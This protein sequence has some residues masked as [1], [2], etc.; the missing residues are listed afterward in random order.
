MNQLIAAIFL[1]SA[2]LAIK[3]IC[4]RNR[5]KYLRGERVEGLIGTVR[6]RPADMALL[7]AFVASLLAYFYAAYLASAA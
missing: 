2:L 3:P 5:A 4:D 7:L 6:H 1:A